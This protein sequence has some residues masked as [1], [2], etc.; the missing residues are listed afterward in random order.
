M[1]KN[2]TVAVFAITLVST[3]LFPTTFTEAR[4]TDRE[5]G[6]S[7][8]YE[9]YSRA[10]NRL[11]DDI[12]EDLFVPLLFGI[13]LNSI[14]SDFGDPRGG[15]TREHEGQD[16]IAPLGTPIVTP[17]EAVVTRIG[18]GESAG[19]YVYTRNPGGE[20]FR[21]MH[22]DAFADIDEGDVLEAGDFIGTVGDTGNAMGGVAHLHF[23]IRDEEALDPYPRITVE[24]TL[25][26]K[27]ELVERMFENLDDADEVAEFLTTSH[28]ADFRTAL[29]AGYDL[30]EEITEALEERGIVSVADLVAQLERI[31]DSIPTVVT[32]EL[33]LGS[34]GTSVSLM[35]TYLIFTQTGP[36]VTVLKSAGAT[37][38]YGPVTA[39]AIREYQTSAKLPVTGVYDVATRAAMME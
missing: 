10:I 11:D 9:S 21:Y 3:V 28:T 19:K 26:E 29:N 15:G 33:T 5:E 8:R 24:L 4:H 6:S 39:A 23:E 27:M 20:T 38:Y 13:K 16:L 17:T 35:Q 32:S 22:L 31:I 36:A 7:E 14:V 2:Y 1:I 34:Q 12:V 37:G 30:P 18:T 25:K